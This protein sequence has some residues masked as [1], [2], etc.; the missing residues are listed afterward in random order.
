MTKIKIALQLFLV[1][2]GFLGL[3]AQTKKVNKP[4][5]TTL[6]NPVNLSYRFCLDGN[7]PR[8][9]AADPT[10]ITFKGEY[11]LFASR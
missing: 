1:C 7:I 4:V 8:R 9:E 6:C 5:Q 10:M 3:N 2:F 11:Y